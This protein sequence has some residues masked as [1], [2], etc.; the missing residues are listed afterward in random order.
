M[1]D[2]LGNKTQELKESLKKSATK[3]K[4]LQEE[5]DDY[6]IHAALIEG[7]YKTATIEIDTMKKEIQELKQQ[8][9][10][11]TIEIDLLK[12]IRDDL[13]SLRGTCM[14]S[15]DSMNKSLEST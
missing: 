3:L 10:D 7:K 4:N 8:N 11:Y 1:E 2:D 12:K 15:V 5:Y 13:I 6:K 9:E 14:T